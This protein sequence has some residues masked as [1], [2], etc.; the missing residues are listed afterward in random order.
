MGAL[1]VSEWLWQSARL[2]VLKERLQSTPPETIILRTRARSTYQSAR[3]QFQVSGGEAE[4]RESHEAFAGFCE[5]ITL[6]LQAAGLHIES[7]PPSEIDGVEPNSASLL[8]EAITGEEELQRVQLFLA[9][10]DVQSSRDTLPCTQLELQ[11]L[12][13]LAAAL[14]EKGDSDARGVEAVWFAR[15]LR[16]LVPIL[17]ALVMT[18]VLGAA[19]KQAQLNRETMVP[20]RASSLLPGHACESPRQG[21]FHDHYFFHTREQQGP[22]IEFDLEG[23]PPV[24]QLVIQNRSDCPGCSERAVP[25]VVEVSDDRLKWL[26][27]ARRESDFVTWQAGFPPSPARWLRLRSQRRTALHLKQVRIVTP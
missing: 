17:G 20:W 15:G 12:Q 18:V 27:V 21:C 14:V 8:R 13:E 5:S 24:A 10:Q 11:A 22:W 23:M 26:E 2:R 7:R 9:A 25:L 1:K 6:S 16:V 4:G 19:L 3:R